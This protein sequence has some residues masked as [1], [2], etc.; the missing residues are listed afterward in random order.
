MF[1]IFKKQIKENIE[2]VS[3]KYYFD[4]VYNDKDYSYIFEY[5]GSELVPMYGIINKEY[6]KLPKL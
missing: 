1:N 2:V 4:F 3:K 6:N 5:R